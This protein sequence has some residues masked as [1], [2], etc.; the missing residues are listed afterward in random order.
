MVPSQMQ[1]QNGGVSMGGSMGMEYQR[2][3]VDENKVRGL[4]RAALKARGLKL[5]AGQHLSLE[6][7]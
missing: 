4:L 7:D 5:K 6:P 3:V 1:H 2:L